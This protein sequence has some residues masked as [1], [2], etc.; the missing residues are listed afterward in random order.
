MRRSDFSLY[1]MILMLV[2][3]G[4]AGLYVGFFGAGT[5]EPLPMF[6]G[7]LFLL[8]GL[9]LLVRTLNR[10]QPSPVTNNV[11][12]G[13]SGLG[14]QARLAQ[15]MRA[16]YTN[17][18]YAL[19]NL[20]NPSELDRLMLVLFDSM[21][22]GT[23]DI[24]QAIEGLRSHLRQRGFFRTYGDRFKVHLVWNQGA[25]GLQW[26]KQTPDVWQLRC[27]WNRLLRVANLGPGWDEGQTVAPRWIAPIRQEAVVST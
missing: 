24:D 12:D 21:E 4:A 3:F 5:V 27:N 18:A 9:Y 8:L 19:C 17:P 11:L 14:E 25:A 10:R 13:N 16:F 7:G 22:A 6:V 1:L 20:A 15:E 2:G 26:T 23:G